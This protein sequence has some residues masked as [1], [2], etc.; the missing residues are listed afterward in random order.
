METKIIYNL[1]SDY[2]QVKLGIIGVGNLKIY[3]IR[4][5]IFCFSPWNMYLQ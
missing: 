3:I 1:E 2:N 4:N 5:Y